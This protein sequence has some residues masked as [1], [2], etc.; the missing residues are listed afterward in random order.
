MNAALPLWQLLTVLAVPTFM[1]GLG[2]LMNQTALN[3]LDDKLE[4]LSDKLDKRLDKIEA[5]QLSFRKQMHEEYT[6]LLGMIG[7]QAQQLVRLESR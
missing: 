2:I 4:R 6:G 5:E 3:R 7:S 1:V